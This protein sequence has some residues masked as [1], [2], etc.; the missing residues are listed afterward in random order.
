M[1]RLYAIAVFSVSKL[2]HTLKIQR[3]YLEKLDN[4]FFPQITTNVKFQINE[5]TYSLK[6]I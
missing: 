2:C 5:I 6:S 3:C 1:V 4:Q